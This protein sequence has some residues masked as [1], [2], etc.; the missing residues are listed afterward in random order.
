MTT[1]TQKIT[2]TTDNGTDLYNNATLIADQHLKLLINLTGGTKDFTNTDT[3]TLN[4]TSD[5]I[6]VIGKNQVTIMPKHAT[7]EIFIKV[8]KDKKFFN[9]PQSF[10][11]NTSNTGYKPQSFS[12]KVSDISSDTLSLTTDKFYIETPSGENKPVL[13]NP[14]RVTITTIVRDNSGAAIP[15]LRVN[16]SA[17]SQDSLS[18]VVLTD[19]CGH[20][21][22][23]NTDNF[24]KYQQFTLT[25]DPQGNLK[26]YAFPQESQ[27]VVLAFYSSIEGL[28]SE[29]KS[30][31][32][33]FIL[34]L[35]NAEFEDHLVAPDI[36]EL[37]DD[38]LKPLEDEK[39]FNIKIPPYDGARKTD[40]ILYLVNDNV[41][42]DYVEISDLSKLDDY[43]Y[44]LP[45]SIFST[46]KENKFSYLIARENSNI[47]YSD[48]IFVKYAGDP[49]DPPDS[50]KNRVFDPPKIYSSYGLNP[51]F[52]LNPGDTINFTTINQYRFNGGDTLYVEI[53]ADS[54]DNQKVNPG[55]TVEIKLFIKSSNRGDIPY[56]GTIQ[57]PKATSP[58]TTSKGNISIPISVTGN[59]DSSSDGRAAV[60]YIEYYKVDGDNDQYSQ[61]WQGYI[62]TTL[63]GGGIN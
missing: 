13:T 2:V 54:A 52:I 36:A 51:D 4:P 11:V 56:K 1:Q 34:D 22:Q 12:F 35:E 61:N 16:I 38:I 60:I 20:P 6:T 50:D 3:I 55:D 25:T 62:D 19:V 41:V 42:G 44:Q 14:N 7:A 48:S 17:N 21:L 58:A 37:Y 26:F 47:R 18:K 57:L 53:E 8:S 49:N 63:P 5:W 27:S 23:T 24:A 10:T 33:L 15:N 39:Y 45:Y 28:F 32:I 9:T 43:S 29:R 30:K 31:N 40:F 46:S 59:I